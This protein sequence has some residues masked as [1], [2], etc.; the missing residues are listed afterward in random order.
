MVFIEHAPSSADFII[1]GGGTAGLALASRL[2]HS[3]PSTSNH[4]IL[5]LEAG[6]NRTGHP[7]TS[8]P[9]GAFAAHDSELD[10]NYDSIPQ[11][12]LKDRVIHM[13]AGKALS[14]AT[15][16][17]Y[18]LWNRGPKDDYDRWGEL[19]DEKGWSY[20]GLLPYFKAMEHHFDDSPKSREQ[21][22]FSGP[23]ATISVTKSDPTRQYPLRSYLKQGFQEMGLKINPDYNSGDSLGVGE[24]VENWKDGKRQA[25][26]QVL[27][28]SK[29]QILCGAWIE[30]IIIEDTESG[31][32]RATGVK[33]VDGPVIKAE[34]EVVIS[35]GAY[36]TPQVLMHSGIGPA[37]ELRRH[38]IPVILDQ[39]EVGKNYF[40]HYTVPMY[41]KVREPEKAVA[42]G[43]PDWQKVAGYDKGSPY[44]YLVWESMPSSLLKSALEKDASTSP[45]TTKHH[46]MTTVDPLGLLAPKR[47]HTEMIPLYAPAA[48]MGLFPFDGTII[49]TGTLCMQNTSRGHITISSRDPKSFPLID[50][51]FY[52]TETDRAALRW[53]IRRT[54]KLM[55]ETEGGK[56][57]VQPDE[58][59]PEGYP[60]LTASS[61]D[62]EI[63]ERVRRVGHVWNHPAGTAAM[64]TKLSKGVVDSKCRVH[65][66]EGLRVVDASVIPVSIA[67]HL[68]VCVYAIGWRMGDVIAE[69]YR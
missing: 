41:W 7:L 19:T 39:P 55:Q 38:D 14:G 51:N 32:K 59:A 5:V 60:Q 26:N 69:A 48:K 52:T 18:G 22:G 49:T 13:S 40:D 31:G 62:E 23:M 27:D 2:S 33:I 57:M 4:S 66:V 58:V 9:S 35:T 21:H 37:E 17:N 45:T 11:K 43:H 8:T 67:A 50:P 68:M 3:L 65:G 15:A 64:E 53:G 46:N 16:V 61:T 12:Q 1:I 54:L 10:W 47:I 30:R 6:E 29:V 20:E 44:D 56:A 63:D 25:A 34:K 42:A 24:L 28:L 36:R